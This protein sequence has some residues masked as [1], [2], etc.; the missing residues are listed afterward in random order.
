M[1]EDQRN[2]QISLHGEPPGPTIAFFLAVSPGWLE[3]M[4]IPLLDGRDFRD[5]DATPNVALVNQAFVKAFFGGRNPVG[6]S[7]QVAQ[8]FHGPGWHPNTQ[9]GA[10]F[11]RDIIIIGVVKD[12][13]YR[14]VREKITPQVYFPVHRLS[15]AA[16]A[17]VDTLQQ[18]GGEVIVVRTASDNINKMAA[19]LPRVVTQTDPGFRVSDVV[20]QTE[21]ISDQTIRERLLATLAAF[22]AAVAL[23]L[24]IVGLYGVLHY[25]VVQ[26]EREIGI[27]IALGAAARNIARIVSARMLLMVLAGTLVG[28]A[29]A[30]GSVRFVQSLLYGVNGTAISMIVIPMTVLLAAAA[31][32]AVPAVL[33]AVR[34]DP[35][36]MLRAE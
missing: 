18:L 13:L 5:S 29:A 7:F 16:E 23:L 32:A 10:V 33:R 14:N 6:R 34:I 4:Q 19:L 26:R 24:A 25:S 36:I 15:A 12:V 21:L 2:F 20:T 22:F 17:P 35:V 30:M 9:Y 1:S 28:L 3:T 8:P 31:C 11:E 27:R